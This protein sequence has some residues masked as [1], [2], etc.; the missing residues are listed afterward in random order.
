MKP[1]LYGYSAS[2]DL[3]QL[4]AV[5]DCLYRPRLRLITTMPDYKK[6]AR[7]GGKPSRP[8]GPRRDT[9]RS[10]EPQER[11]DAECN[12]CGAS[13]QVP[14]RP[15]GKKPVYCRDCYK[16]KEEGPSHGARSTRAEAAPRNADF[17]K[18]LDAI[19]G[20]LDRILKMLGK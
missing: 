8:F 20:K 2:A 10:F 9:G 6:S 14:F 18:R 4:L 7:F 17:A 16:G 3:S 1:A 15:N 19:D 11:Y 12:N 5:Q 13:C